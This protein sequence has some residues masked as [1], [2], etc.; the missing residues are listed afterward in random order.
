MG[1]ALGRIAHDRTPCVVIRPRR[2]ER[3]YV[4]CELHV[5][6]S[7]TLVHDTSRATPG[8]VVTRRVTEQ[9]LYRGGSDCH[10]IARSSPTDGRNEIVSGRSRFQGRVRAHHATVIARKA[11]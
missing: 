7:P 3:V 9:R 8:I 4:D 6:K 5:P 11:E 10:V 2:A 1:V